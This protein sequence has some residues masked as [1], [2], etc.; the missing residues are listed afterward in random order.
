MYGCTVQVADADSGPLVASGQTLSFE[1]S[2][3]HS[4]SGT[5]KSVT[6]SL[7]DGSALNWVEGLT[8]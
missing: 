8:F 7:E 1:E 2:G 6:V 4:T 5:K 3:R